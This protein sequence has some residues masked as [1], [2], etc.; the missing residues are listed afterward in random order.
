MTLTITFVKLGTNSEGGIFG[1]LKLLDDATVVKESTAFSGGNSFN[2]LDDGQYRLRLDIRG[3][4]DS[5]EANTDG[6][7]KPFYGI[8]QVSQDVQDDQGVHW[9]MQVE[10]GTIRARLNPSGGA[11]DHGDYIHGKKR[12]RDYTHGCI[13]DRSEVILSYLWSLESP[14]AGIDV[15]VSGGVNFELESLIRK[16]VGKKLASSGRTKRATRKR[17]T[18]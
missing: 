14:P 5:N 10:W 8:Q 18:S 9:D 6:T 15:F 11:P 7:L 12:P 17:V 4:E 13:C 1:D 3:G 16:N 2:P